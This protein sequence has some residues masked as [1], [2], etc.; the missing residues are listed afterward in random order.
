MANKT[1]N[2]SNLNPVRTK[3]EA[4]ERGRAGGMA[5]GAARRRRKSLQETARLV[6]KLPLNDIG[7]NRMKR[8]G[9]NIDGVDPEDIITQLGIVIGIAGKA[10][11]GDAKAAKVFSDW[12]EDA[13]RHKHEK[14]EL[15]K[16]KQEVEKLKAEIEKLKAET[17]LLKA[18]GQAH[19]E[20]IQDDGFLAALSG[21]AEED[22]QEGPDEPEG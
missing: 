15:E 7:V 5:S 18:K 11:N 17:E 22:W 1:G 16:K 14:V 10:A 21:S 6:A 8:T 2:E 20:E 19:D 4:R 9:V 13:E 3:D 12:M